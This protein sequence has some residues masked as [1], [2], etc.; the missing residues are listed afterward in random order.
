MKLES[1]ALHWGYEPEATTKAAA[2][3]IYQ[4]TSYAFDDTQ[5][6]ADLFDLKVPGNIYTR[7]MNPT[8]AVL[9]ERLAQ[10]EGGVGALAVLA[11]PQASQ[12]PK[13]EPAPQPAPVAPLRRR[14]PPWPRTSRSACCTLDSTSLGTST[15]SGASPM[16][17]R[18]ESRE[19]ATPEPRVR[20][21]WSRARRSCSPTLAC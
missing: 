12:A 8:N 18:R 6:G 15:T 3:P 1:L 11:A 4:T 19:P 14:A 5:H 10:L 16:R 7:I 13:P 21:S 20:C 17:P 2:V 9:E